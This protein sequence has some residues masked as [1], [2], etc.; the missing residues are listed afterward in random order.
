MNNIKFNKAVKLYLDE[1]IVLRVLFDDGK[2]KKINI[3]K[4]L[5]KLPETYKMLA[6]REFFLKGKLAGWGGITWSKDV[7][8][9]VDTI[10]LEGE[11]VES[12]PDY[13]NLII[14]FKVKQARLMK[15]LSQI[16]LAKLS[17]VDQ[18]QI[19][20]LEKGLFNPSINFLTKIFKA[21]DKQIDL[22]IK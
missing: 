21:L 7:D 2:T 5:P 16:E 20:K 13:L 22:I 1:K 17:G 12:E 4:L 10:Y 8:L 15:E 18:S 11:E 19:S 6:N 14:G 3:E 9:S